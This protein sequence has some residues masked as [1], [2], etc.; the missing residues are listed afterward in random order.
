MHR[1]AKARVLVVDDEPQL[2]DL[3]ADALSGPDIEIAVASTGEQALELAADQDVDLV[4]ADLYLG[5]CTG[6]EVIDRLRDADDDLPA[7]VITGNAN[8]QNLTEASRRRPVELMAKPLDVDR[9]LSTIRL[10]LARRADSQKRS[11]RMRRLCHDAN[12]RRKDVQERL[13]TTCADLTFAYRNLS[14]Q[15]ALQKI[16]LGYQNEL[17]SAKTDDDV[18]RSLFRL[19]VRRSGPVYGA[20]L[21]CDSSAQ[22]NIIGR[23]GVPYP[24]PVDFCKAL[25]DPLVESILA[26]PQVILFDAGRSCEMFDASV[27]R[28][29]PGLSILLMPLIPAPGELIGMVV[30]YRKGEQPFT[31][32][33]V[34]VAEMIATPTAVAVRRND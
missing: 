28:Y 25:S 17:L 5:D 8:T 4:V 26:T 9:L 24:D 14:S 31:E 6:L 3:L 34:A 12:R 7:V 23:F 16:V 22:L 2:R 30:L 13:D 33:D 19:F 18:F 11:E 27:H 21:V 20:A 15:M 32:H 29:L 1:G 10:E